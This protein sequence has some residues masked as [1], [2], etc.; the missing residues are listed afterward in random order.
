MTRTEIAMM[1]K[2]QMETANLIRA[3]R[4]SAGLTQNDLAKR[5]DMARTTLASYE[6]GRNEPSHSRVREILS[7]CGYE[8]VVQKKRMW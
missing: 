3:C 4:E 7:A 8:L 6:S 1:A 5:V 2:I